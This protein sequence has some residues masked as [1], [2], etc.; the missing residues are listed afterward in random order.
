MKVLV[1]PGHSP[2][3]GASVTL[4]NGATLNEESLNW[5]IAQELD[6]A[7]SQW[8]HIVRLSRAETQD[9][10][11][12]TRARKA[13]SWGADIAIS[14]HHNM[15]T[16][17]KK[18][19]MFAKTEVYVR[20]P[21]FWITPKPTHAQLHTPLNRVRVYCTEPVT[22]ENQ[23]MQARVATVLNAYHQLGFKDVCLLECGYLNAPSHQKLINQ[24]GYVKSMALAICSWVNERAKKEGRV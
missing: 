18:A 6:A 10:S 15:A 12:L 9:I 22:E 24:P 23:W 11:L 21:N 17:I 7:L 1:D 19:D 14:I 3:R 13:V 8:G 20:E 16:D 2:G 4:E 5:Q